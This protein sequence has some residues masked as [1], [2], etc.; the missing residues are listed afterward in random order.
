MKLQQMKKGQY[1]ITL[2][3]QIVKAKGWNKGD[4]IVV[5]IDSRGNIILKKKEYPIKD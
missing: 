3:N 5:E 1:F 2:P 4:Y